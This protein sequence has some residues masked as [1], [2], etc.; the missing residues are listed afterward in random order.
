MLTH[1]AGY[2]LHWCAFHNENFRLH[3]CT[4][5]SWLCYVWPAQVQ[6]LCSAQAPT[7]APTRFQAR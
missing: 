2:T 1:S 6:T 5:K 4:K 3:S 7:I